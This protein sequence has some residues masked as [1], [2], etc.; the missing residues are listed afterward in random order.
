MP[1]NAEFIKKNNIQVNLVFFEVQINFG[2]YEQYNIFSLIFEE[3]F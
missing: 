3:I 1:R 2:V